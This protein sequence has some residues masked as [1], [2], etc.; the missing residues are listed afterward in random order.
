MDPRSKQVIGILIS[1]KTN[2]ADRNG[3]DMLK[4]LYT[5]QNSM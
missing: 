3:Y 4:H 2:Q 5:K 1:D